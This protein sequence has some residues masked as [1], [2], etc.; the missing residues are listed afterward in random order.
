MYLRNN[1]SNVHLRIVVSSP[2]ILNDFLKESLD[3]PRNTCLPVKC[4]DSF[5]NLRKRVYLLFI[6]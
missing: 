5:A 2:V 4:T 3:K 6:L 1:F